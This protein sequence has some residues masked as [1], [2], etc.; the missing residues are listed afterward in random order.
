MRNARVTA[1]W[2]DGCCAVRQTCLGQELGAWGVLIV[3]SGG[4]VP[5][6]KQRDFGRAR[7][8][9]WIRDLF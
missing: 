2:N 4:V 8:P 3:P 7:L 5:W 6:E 1:A 9:S